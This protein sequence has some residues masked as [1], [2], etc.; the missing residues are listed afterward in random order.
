ML[1]FISLALKVAAL[2]CQFASVALL[3]NWLSTVGLSTYF[4]VVAI[5]SLASQFVSF[6]FV[7]YAFRYFA[8]GVPKEK[9]ITRTLQVCFSGFLIGVIF[10]ALYAYC[11]RKN[12]L[13]IVLT[14][15]AGS[16]G[17]VNNLNRYI[18]INESR[19][20]WCQGVEALQPLAFLL[21]LAL[22]KAVSAEKIFSVEVV[23]AS[24]LAS[25]V[26]TLIIS[27]IIAD[28]GGAWLHAMRNIRTGSYSQGVTK[29]IWRSIYRS[30]SIGFEALLSTTWFNLLIIVS[31]TFGSP[32]LTSSLGVF[33][34]L[35]G[36][37]NA[38]VSVAI[39][40]K[41]RD[42]Y[43]EEYKRKEIAELCLTGVALGCA[44]GV[45]SL[46][47][48]LSILQQIVTPFKSSFIL[49]FNVTNYPPIWAGFVASLFIFMHLSFA[50][51]GSNLNRL[52]V[53]AVIWGIVSF[54]T[55]LYLGVR[56]VAGTDEGVLVAYLS[57]YVISIFVASYP[58]ARALTRPRL[59]R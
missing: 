39:T 25:F 1:R 48:N 5:A 30:L 15:F 3:A 17:Q 44:A 19:L 29:Q 55:L 8:Q 57:S 37:V 51:L 26:A 49:L 28:S 32:K 9:I 13:W 18:L 59:K 31:D 46:V 56:Y 36:V 22:T 7:R 10:I 34:R 52:R 20:V 27:C 14:L 2:G 43:A 16:L 45:G 50:A 54:L 42:M 12:I 40:Y 38:F 53:V 41:L 35:T 33:Q 23:L 58:L 11:A 4:S 47:F 6:G 24:Y 21:L